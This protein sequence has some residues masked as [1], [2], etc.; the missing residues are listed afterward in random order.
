MKSMTSILRLPIVVACLSLGVCAATASGATDLWI[1]HITSAGGWRTGISVYYSGAEPSADVVLTRYD[2]IGRPIG[3]P[4]AITASNNLWSLVPDTALD[5]DGSARIQSDLKILVKVTYRFGDTQSV[6]AFFVS[7]AVREEWVLPNT[8]L[9]WLDWSGIALVNSNDFRTS[10]S[11]EAWRDGTRLRE[12]TISLSA[13]SRYA[14]VSGEIWDGLTFQEF[15]TAVIKAPFPIP[16]PIYI[17]GNQEQ[18]RHLSFRAQPRPQSDLPMAL[19]NGILVDGTGGTPLDDAVVIVRRGKIE[20]VGK[21][22]S[23]S[24]PGDSETIDVEGGYILP[25]FINAHV[26]NAFREDNLRTWAWEGVTTVRDVGAQEDP[27]VAFGLRDAMSTNPSRARIVAAGP[28]VTV[29]GGYPLVPQGFPALAVTSADD[30]REKIRRL[31]DLGADLVK[32]CLE[33]G[34]GNLPM[35]SLEEVRAIV[36]TA[37]ERRVPVTAHLSRSRQLEMALDAGVDGDE[38]AVVDLMSDELAARMTRQGMFLVPTLAA[39]RKNAT[40]MRNLSTFLR[41]GGKVA[42]G[43]DGGYLSG[44]EIG[45]P[46]SELE[47]MQEAGMTPMQIIV[48]ATKTAGETCGLGRFLGTI[49]AGKL[50]DLLVVRRNPLDNLQALLDVAWVIHGG[51]VIRRPGTLPYTG[52]E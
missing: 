36:E 5:S 42:M 35:L 52:K 31:L 30:A 21:R 49:E 37:H 22:G 27:P 7:D 47:A 3:T 11:L 1:G 24:I 33:P 39:L 18:A 51:T 45:M 4:A 8:V 50:A 28:L 17:S 32:I 26:H 29:P 14:K 13:H 44:L 38:H 46:I 2:D 40:A 43:N 34:S 6:C 10:V 20:S 16:S 19:V 12:R 15:D 48:S 41:A 25:G 9:P 23:L